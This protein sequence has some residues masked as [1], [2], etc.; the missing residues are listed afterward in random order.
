M[1]PKLK[2]SKSRISAFPP[3]FV[4][5]SAEF[6][7]PFRSIFGLFSCI[8]LAF[9]SPR[10]K[11]HLSTIFHPPFDRISASVPL[12]FRPVQPYFVGLSF[13]PSKMALFRHISSSVPPNFGL[14]STKYRQ[15]W[16]FF[17]PKWQLRGTFGTK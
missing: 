16:P 12:Y 10:L 5:R 3:Y 17:R 15:L 9:L 13:T 6:R 7:P 4:L 2:L 14:S 8:L 11:W 1:T